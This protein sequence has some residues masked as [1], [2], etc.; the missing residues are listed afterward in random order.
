MTSFIVIEDTMF[1][2]KIANIFNWAY[3]CI[4]SIFYIY[5]DLLK[6]KGFY[7]ECFC[8]KI[9]TILKYLGAHTKHIASKHIT[10]KH[11]K[12]KHINSKQ[13]KTISIEVIIY[14]YFTCSI[15]FKV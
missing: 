3:F 13:L 11:I 1:T 14:F 2:F 10:T 5:F 9:I 4:N 6:S 8:K 15:K 12:T 7:L